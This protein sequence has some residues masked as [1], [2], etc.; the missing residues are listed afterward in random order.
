MCG[1]ITHP[2]E[3][4]LAA[5]IVQPCIKISDAGNDVLKLVLILPLDSAALSDSKV[6]CQ[7]DATVGRV[8]RQPTAAA[9]V[10]GGREADLMVTRIVGG[11]GKLACAATALGDDAV[12]IVEDFLYQKL[13]SVVCI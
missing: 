1:Q 6:K 5:D 9:T 13:L 3:D 2:L 11:K 7:A 4:L 8:C 10:G 12:M